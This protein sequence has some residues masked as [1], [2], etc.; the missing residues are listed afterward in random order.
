MQTIESILLNKE[1]LIKCFIQQ[2]NMIEAEKGLDWRNK[3]SKGDF[4]CSL[5]VKF[6]SLLNQITLNWDTQT[7]HH[8]SNRVRALSEMKGCFEYMMMLIMHNYP[9]NL[10]VKYLKNE[11]Q[12]E[13]T[14]YGKYADRM[15]RINRDLS[16]FM[17]AVDYGTKEYA[18][19]HM[20]SFLGDMCCLIGYSGDA[21]FTIL[22]GKD[23]DIADVKQMEQAA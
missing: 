19:K 1:Q 22:M 4:M 16:L 10:M 20:M 9:I 18:I 11:Y 21:L 17:L 13:K 6:A 2:E 12:E 3:V 8:R 7:H 15:Q 5:Q 14:C 23:I